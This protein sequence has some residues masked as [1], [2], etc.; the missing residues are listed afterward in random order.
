[1]TADASDERTRRGVILAVPTATAVLGS[2]CLSFG[3]DE[4]ATG[5][6]TYLTVLNRSDSSVTLQCTVEN[7]TM[8]EVVLD[9]SMEVPS[10]E[11]SELEFSLRFSESDGT[12]RISATISREDTGEEASER[13]T[14]G[15]ATGSQGLSGGI[16]EDG[17]L[18][19]S[20]DVQ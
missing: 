7:R 20:T 18:G 12:A 16:G 9:E 14:F 2:G 10:D 3:D 17:T 4:P 5:I 6:D 8:D 13:S 11:R 19:L 15:S 1:M